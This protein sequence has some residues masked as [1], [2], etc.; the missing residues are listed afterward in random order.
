MAEFKDAS[1][2]KKLAFLFIVVAHTLELHGFSSGV[3]AGYNSVRIA[4]IIGFL[5]LLVAFG[6]ALCYVFLD[7]LS[8][9]KPTLICF[10]IFSWIAGNCP[11]HLL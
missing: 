11:I 10:I 6:L 7:E 1:L 8:D 3:L 5:C 2:W 4:T 9:S